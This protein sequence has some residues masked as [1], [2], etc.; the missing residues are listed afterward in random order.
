M[1]DSKRYLYNALEL[2]CLSA[3]QVTRDP[4]YRQLNLS[5]AVSWISLARQ[6]EATAGQLA[7]W[8]AVDLDKSDQTVSLVRQ[9]P[10]R[11]Q[12][13]ANRDHGLVLVV[14]ERGQDARL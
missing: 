4:H 14:S 2:E 12:G 10:P 6:E 11:R 9:C 13:L 8:N 1:L 3:A 5:L 7:S